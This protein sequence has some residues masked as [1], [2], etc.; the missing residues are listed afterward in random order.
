[1]NDG[2]NAL[3]PA[4]SQADAQFD[5]LKRLVLDSVASPHSKA[6]YATSLSQFYSWFR[7]DWKGPLVK[8]CVNAYKAYLLNAHL[9]PSTINCKIAAIK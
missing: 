1:M 6:Q 5:F 8:G 7:K 4:Q 3:I 9:A 2:Q